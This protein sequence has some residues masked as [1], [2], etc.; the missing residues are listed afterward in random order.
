M[1]RP[2]LDHP[3]IPSRGWRCRPCFICF[4]LWWLENGIGAPRFTMSGTTVFWDYG[5]I[6]RAINQRRSADALLFGSRWSLRTTSEC[7]TKLGTKSTDLSPRK[8]RPPFWW[9]WSDPKAAVRFVWN[10][11]TPRTIRSSIRVTILIR[12]TSKLW[13]K[14]R[15]ASFRSP[16]T[17]CSSS[18]AVFDKK[19]CFDKKNPEFATFSRPR[20]KRIKA[21]NFYAASWNER[22]PS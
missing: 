1:T 9:R 3:S 8:T 19:I 4:R 12:T 17:S 21:I 6:T 5:D 20:R 11:P 16:R 15:N 7:P 10:P 13:W 2:F 14:V 18:K 22:P